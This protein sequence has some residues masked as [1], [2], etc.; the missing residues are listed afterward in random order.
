MDKITYRGW[1]DCYRISNNTVSIIINA[2]AGGR[3]M[4]FER[5]GI[6]VI[7]EDANQDGLLLGDYLG[8][9]FDPDGGRFDYGQ[10]EKTRPLHA[11]TYMGPWSGKILNE[12][13][14]QITSLPDENLGI[15]STR[16]FIL[17]PH[18]PHLKVIQT[19]K[20]ISDS[21]TEYFFW[22]RTLVNL[23]GLLFIPLNP[24]SKIQGQ[25]GRYIWGDPVV[26]GNDPDDKGVVVKENIF[27]LDPET[28]SW[29]KYG[30]DSQAG[31]MAYGYKSILF[32]KKYS[33]TPEAKYTEHYGQTN[34]FYTNCKTFAEMEP[35][36]PTAFLKPGEEY[37]YEEDWYLLEYPPCSDKG[38][39][40]C[41]AAKF[42]E[43]ME[44]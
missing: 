41:T 37:S 4:S 19:M 33:Y 32:I 44:S 23:G 43:G 13:S 34:V 26:Y 5:N 15:L 28:A 9:K 10:E 2:S 24:Q 25:W 20:N 35:I 14:L 6:N 38:F 36:S 8:E 22:G 16:T 40:V 3:I 31:W 7:Y 11:Q 29:E 18:E 21:P 17:D 12:Q 39:E 42:I 1:V 30:N 27:S